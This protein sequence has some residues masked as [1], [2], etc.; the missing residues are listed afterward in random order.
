M[1]SS[2][3]STFKKFYKYMGSYICNYTLYKG[4]I[5]FVLDSQCPSACEEICVLAFGKRKR[6]ECL[7]A[8]THR[9][10]NKLYV[11]FNKRQFFVTVCQTTLSEY[12]KNIA[13]IIKTEVLKKLPLTT[14]SRNN[15]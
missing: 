1:G 15:L 11:F 10:K 6:N 2:S 4:R 12:Q 3:K 7:E 5:D 13:S 14:N 9:Y 8:E